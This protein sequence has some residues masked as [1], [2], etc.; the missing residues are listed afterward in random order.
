MTVSELLDKTTALTNELDELASMFITAKELTEDE[1]Q[2][3]DAMKMLNSIASECE[4]LYKSVSVLNSKT[5]AEESMRL[6]ILYANAMSAIG[7]LKFYEAI[8]DSDEDPNEYFRVV[9]QICTEGLQNGADDSD[10][11]MELR[12]CYINSMVQNMFHYTEM[13]SWSTIH[14]QVEKFTDLDFILST[15]WYVQRHADQSASMENSDMETAISWYNHS[16][17]MFDLAQS[18]SSTTEGMKGLASAYLA[19]GSEISESLLGM[20]VE[21]SKEK[22]LQAES[23]LKPASDHL[24]HILEVSELDDEEKLECMI[25][26]CETFVRMSSL[27]NVTDEEGSALRVKAMQLFQ[28]VRTLDPEA[29]TDDLDSLMEEAEEER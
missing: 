1:Q 3:D 2:L 11:K 26:Q 18:M 4:R 7:S 24:T 25:M 15:A 8:N 22:W 28:Q 9:Q 23:Y 20:D 14:E 21:D 17:K 27:P 13:D 6:Y 19:C 16:I 5:P 12:S 10:L 29:I